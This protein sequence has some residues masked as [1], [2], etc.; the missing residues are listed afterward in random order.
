MKICAYCGALNAYP[1]ARCERCA[2][3]FPISHMVEVPEGDPI[4]DRL[5]GNTRAI[6]KRLSDEN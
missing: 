2:Q 4:G 3:I 6:P 1:S 5:D